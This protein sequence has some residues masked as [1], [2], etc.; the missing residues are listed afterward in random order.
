M[1]VRNLDQ[2]NH[3]LNSTLAHK[4]LS[5]EIQAAWSAVRSFEDVE[6]LVRACDLVR[7]AIPGSFRVELCRGLEEPVG[8]HYHDDGKISFSGLVCPEGQEKV[9]EVIQDMLKELV[10][11]KRTI[12]QNIPV[13][14]QTDEPEFVY[15]GDSKGIMQLREVRPGLC[16]LRLTIERSLWLLE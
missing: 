2:A 7:K 15:K 9:L 13:I 16:S 1:S 10:D 6:G 5:A 3:N 4:A 14:P 12:Y 8:A 11:S